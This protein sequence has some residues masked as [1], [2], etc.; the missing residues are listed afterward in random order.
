VVPEGGFPLPGAQAARMLVERLEG[1][2]LVGRAPGGVVL[3]R[4][5]G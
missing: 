1:Y 5:C 2:V 3:L 4:R